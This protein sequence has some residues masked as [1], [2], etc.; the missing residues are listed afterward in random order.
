[1]SETTKQPST[2]HWVDRV[3]ENIKT[4]QQE[5]QIK[6]LH[7]DDMKTPS[8]RVHT[9]AL[10]GVLIHDIVAQALRQDQPHTKNT[11]VF[12]DMDPMDSLPGYLPKDMFE[13]H[14]GEPLYRI[15]T[16]SLDECGID[17]S[18]ATVQEKEE[19]KNAK[20]FAQLY[21]ID[22][23]HAFRKL[24]ATPVV[25]WS[26]E[27]YESGQMDEMIRFVLDNVAQVKRVYE[28][29]AEYKLPK[30]W[31]PFQVICPE[32]GKVGTTLTTDWDGELVAFECQPNK[33]TWAKGCGYQGKISPFGGTGK[34]LWKVDWPAHW[35]VMGVNVEGAGKDHSSAG[36]SRDMANALVTRVFN[37]VPPFD[38]PY[39]W[40][41][42]RGAKMS[43]S[44]GV[45]TSAREFVKLYPQAVG[46]FLFVNHN[47]Y[48]VIDFDPQT[49]A[50]PDLFDEFD[51]AAHAY[52]TKEV[53]NEKIAR[54]FEL[55][56]TTQIPQEHFL[57]RF[58]DVAVWMQFPEIDLVEKFAQVKGSPL[59][60]Q[61]LA[62]LENR[63][64]YAQ[65]WLDRYATEEFQ[66]RAKR[67]LPEAAKALSAEQIA[68]LDQAVQIVDQENWT[69]REMELQTK[70]YELSKQSI[71]AKKAFAAIY[72]AFLG[73]NNGPRA[74]WFI[75]SIDPSL[76]KHRIEELYAITTQ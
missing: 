36:G 52:W 57:P 62:E 9:G 70:L 45:G 76:R 44:K 27:L 40:I 58:R 66:F 17:L 69:G 29:V 28:E 8:G 21:A 22:F 32:C 39:E 16:P 55:S 46:R 13:K 41:L 4:W 42:I 64:Q 7:V 60:E 74:A 63:K 20:N 65:V 67:E 14:M 75:N 35:Q 3:V 25:V 33:V 24:G 61:E 37:N 71:G 54:S 18:T 68:F 51:A 10:R 73:K 56:H 6:E 19:L 12:N 15:P 2:F 5:K 50:I 1:M 34:L 49:M 31:Y 30:A 48:Q 47:Y 43:S 72:L 59:T 38:I 53:G 26:H 23:I 11:Y